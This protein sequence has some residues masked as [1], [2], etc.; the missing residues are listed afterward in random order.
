MKYV[1]ISRKKT[2]RTMSEKTFCFSC[3]C[4]QGKTKPSQK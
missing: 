4:F 2:I 3:G 1:V